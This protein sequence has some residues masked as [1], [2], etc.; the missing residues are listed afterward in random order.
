MFLNQGEIKLE[1]NNKKDFFKNNQVKL[2]YVFNFWE[3]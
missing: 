2:K 1:I 3:I